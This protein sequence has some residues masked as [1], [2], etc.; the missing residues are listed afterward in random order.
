LVHVSP[1]TQASLRRA[2]SSAYYAV[3]HFL[4]SEA[5][6]NWK[7]EKLQ[8]ALGR[9]YDHGVMK[10]ASN[11]I[12]NARDFPFLGEKAQLVEDLRFV[13]RTFSQLQEDRHFADYN[14]TKDLDPTD[15]I[16]QVKSAENIFS[17]WPSI[18]GEQ[19]AQAY[20]VSLVVKN[21]K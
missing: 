4:I 15:A 7:N 20:L 18:R 1:P 19:I 10:T 12:L 9:A 5:T 6:S 11:S 2:V 21:R 3:F 16:T 8:A 13:A 17:I 14:L